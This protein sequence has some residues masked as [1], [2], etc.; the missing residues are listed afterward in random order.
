MSKMVGT[1]FNVVKLNEENY[2]EWIRSMMATL[3]VEGYGRLVKG[4]A[5]ADDFGGAAELE[6]AKEK[7]IAVI[8]LSLE[9]SQYPLLGDST[10]PKAVLDNIAKVHRA[11]GFGSRF[12]MRRIWLSLRKSEDETMISW[13][14]RVESYASRLRGVD[15]NIEDEEIIVVLVNGLASTFEPFIVSLDSVGKDQL[16]LEYVKGRLMNE[17]VR[18]EGPI[19][20][21]SLVDVKVER[22][23]A[24]AMAARWKGGSGRGRQSIP[25]SDSKG[26]QKSSSSVKCYRCQQRGHIAADC[27]TE[28]EDLPNRAGLAR[29]AIRGETST[30]ET[31]LF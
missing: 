19:G 13:I 6:D 17:F 14:N 23:E 11:R 21:K 9:P 1:R 27:L 2:E 24:S 22:N 26:E 18:Q 29:M 20:D 30:H 15:A 3:V 10:N 12:K 8:T 28:V 31:C 4:T 7:A 16:T 25:D 5:T